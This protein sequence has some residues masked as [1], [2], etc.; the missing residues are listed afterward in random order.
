MPDGKL[1]RCLRN[2]TAYPSL[3]KSNINIKFKMSKCM[4]PG[5]EEEEEE[6]DEAKMY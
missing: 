5:G 4:T 1:L 2:Q 3:T 6:E